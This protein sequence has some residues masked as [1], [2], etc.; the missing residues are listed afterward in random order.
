MTDADDDAFMQ[1]GNVLLVLSHFAIAPALALSAARRLWPEFFVLSA[2]TVV[3][4][5]YHLCQTGAGCVMPFSVMQTS[6]HFFVY[7][8]LAWLT[9]YFTDAKLIHRF[10]AF[11]VYQAFLVPF[12]L[13]YMHSWWIIMAA[14]GLSS[15]LALALILLYVKRLPACDWK[16]LVIAVALIGSGAT[17]HVYGGDPGTKKYT[18]SH[19]VWHVAAM[20]AIYWLLELKDEKAWC[21][22]MWDLMKKRNPSLTWEDF[23]SDITELRSGKLTTLG[24]LGAIEI[25]G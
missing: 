9:F 17:L 2:M 3:S 14:V 8:A 23:S 19:T 7:S 6:D 5:L 20:L 21:Y 22:K 18:W 1:A 11:V 15:I 4:T 12:T 24:S 10:K 13:N 25:L 16:D